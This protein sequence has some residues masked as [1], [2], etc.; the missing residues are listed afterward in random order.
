LAV[1]YDSCPIKFRFARDRQYR[2]DY[3]V[4]V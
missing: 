3:A 1:I 4:L 2:G